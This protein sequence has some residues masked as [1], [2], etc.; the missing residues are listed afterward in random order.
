MNNE[1]LADLIYTHFCE[2]DSESSHSFQDAWDVYEAEHGVI[3]IGTPVDDLVHAAILYALDMR[4]Q[5]Q[6]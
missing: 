1:Q 6:S 4:A 2:E 3:E 5:I